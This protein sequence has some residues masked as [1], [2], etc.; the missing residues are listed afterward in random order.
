MNLV[1]FVVNVRDLHFED[2]AM[3]IFMH[4]KQPWPSHLD[5][6]VSDNALAAR[7]LFLQGEHPH[8]LAGCPSYLES[9]ER[10]NPVSITRL[11]VK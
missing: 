7:V 11:L 3:R 5:K 9:R 8:L 2:K 10:K 6:E 4:Y 1:S